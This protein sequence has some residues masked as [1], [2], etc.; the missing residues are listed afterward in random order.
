MKGSAFI[1]VRLLMVHLTVQLESFMTWKSHNIKQYSNEMIS[2]ANGS[3]AESRPSPKSATQSRDA[4]FV[5]FISTLFSRHYEDI[6]YVGAARSKQ[7]NVRT[8]RKQK[9]Y[10]TSAK[11]VNLIVQFVAF[12]WMSFVYFR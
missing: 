4:L 2:I 12:A 6:R 5:H 10:Q 3:M 9:H 11:N 8:A 1:V 7:L